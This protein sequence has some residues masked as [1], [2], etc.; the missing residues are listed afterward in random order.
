MSSTSPRN[1]IAVAIPCFNESAAIATVIGAWRE[2][3]PE[4]EILVFDNNSTDG[5]A[6][7]AHSLGV[8]VRF[9]ARQGKGHA[10]RAIL[11]QLADRDAVILVDG[12]GT[13]PASKARE[14]L[15]PILSGA[16]EM[17][18][19]S[20]QPVDDGKAMS[21][22]RGLGNVLIRAAFQVFVGQPPGDLLSGYRVFSRRF[23][24]G[25]DLKSEGFE[26][27]TELACE[28]VARS[29]RT[30][31]IA[32]PYYA[33]IA[34]SESK[35]RAFRD[36]RRILAMI[37]RKGIELRPERITSIVAGLMTV[38]VMAIWIALMK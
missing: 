33:R 7:I 34:G 15:A 14:L 16:A 5:T 31:E 29:Y 13:Y 2:A 24:E 8:S 1:S 20:R 19:G 22:I 6:G 26:I 25:V 27:E 30:V 3:L 36:G 23:L 32:V 17:T 37:L 10:V 21:P 4:A 28:A 18:V 12:D 11:D 35:L 9:V 38:V